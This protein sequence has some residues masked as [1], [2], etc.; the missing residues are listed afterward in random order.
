MLSNMILFGKAKLGCKLRKIREEEDG[1]AV[2]EMVIII[3]IVV[4]L[5]FL[6]RGAIFDLFKSMWEAFVV[7]PAENGGSSMGSLDVSEIQ[8]P[9]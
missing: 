3:G 4:V 6:F 5:A 9:A 8:L 2:I 7:T 1:M